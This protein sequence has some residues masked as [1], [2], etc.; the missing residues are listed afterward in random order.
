SQAA[1]DQEEGPEAHARRGLGPHTGL[2]AQ[3]DGGSRSMRIVF[4][5]TPVFA[6]PSL[7][8]LRD[9]GHEVAAVVTRPD[10][11]RRR[12]SS[13]PEPSPVKDEAG[14]AGIPVLSP[15]SIATAEFVEK[16]AAFAP[17]AIVVIW[18]GRIL[19]PAVLEIPPHG[20]INV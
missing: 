18:F 10:R 7:R 13:P 6:I 4:F 15:E 16:L 11:P 12:Q 20:C 3:R 17:E 8:A 5:G 14:K 19:P 2:S 1:A 9:A